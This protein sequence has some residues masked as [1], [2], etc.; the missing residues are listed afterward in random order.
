VAQPAVRGLPLPLE[1]LLADLKASFRRI[2]GEDLAGIYLHGSL[3]QNAFDPARSDVDGIVVTRRALTA[4]QFR[5]IGAWLRR[6]TGT[7]PWTRRL[8]LTFLIQS[9]VLTMNADACIYQAGRLRRGRSDGNPIIWMNV[10]DGG[11]TLAGPPPDSFLPP[12]TAAMLDEA[13]ERE[14]AYLEEEI[15]TKV[16]SR[17]RRV[18]S[19][20]VYAVLTV[21]RI[22]QS[23]E[24]R[25]ID[26]KPAA[27]RW[28]MPR[29]PSSHCA[30]VR[31]ALRAHQGAKQ[32][33]LHLAE[34]RGFLSFAK[35][36]LLRRAPSR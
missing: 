33:V 5:A 13:L 24:T 30:L 25:R 22:L 32:P 16:R 8:Q 31:R 14:L 7:N 9:S 3:T 26:S 27:A 29:L 12:I 35:A 20:R 10:L 1:A 18:P 11:V 6:S 34:I 2:L 17:W 19:Y 28:A 15:T 21:C 4:R 36:E 23:T